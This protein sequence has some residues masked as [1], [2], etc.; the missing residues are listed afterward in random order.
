ML[1]MPRRAAAWQ[2]Q[3]LPQ[4]TSSRLRISRAARAD[5]ALERLTRG[6]MMRAASSGTKRQSCGARVERVDALLLE[7]P[8]AALRAQQGFSALVGL[9]HAAR[10]GSKRRAPTRARRRSSCAP[11]VEGPSGRPRRPLLRSDRRRSGAARASAACPC[12]R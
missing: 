7:I 5:Q 8:E 2:N 4:P 12:P 1:R 10:E 11:H 3:P 9:A 6:A